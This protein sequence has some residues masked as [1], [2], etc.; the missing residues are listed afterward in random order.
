VKYIFVTG[1][2]VSSL[3]KGLAAASIGRLLEDHGYTVALQ[4]FDPYINVFAREL[5]TA[6][7]LPPL[8]Y[9]VSP[10]LLAWPWTLS[11]RP[12]T[13]VAVVTDVAESLLAHGIDR[14]LVVTAHDGNP[15]PVEVAARELNQRHGMAV[16]LFSGWQGMARRLL[17]PIGREI[18][19][20]HAGQSELSIVLYLRPDLAHPEWAVDVANQQMDHPVRVFGSFDRVVPHGHSGRATGGTAEE[21][22]AILAAVAA[23]VGPFLRKLA[24]NGWQN[25]GWM[26]G[27]ER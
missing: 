6:L 25:G 22:E 27:I 5:G 17:A 20:D 1:G 24:A 21:G 7:V 13:L 26:S 8:D 12:T 16:A 19:L 14:L 11:L 4:K 2:V 10:H 23:E 9:G 15:A 18:D 3:G